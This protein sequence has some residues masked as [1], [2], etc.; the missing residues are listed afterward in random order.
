MPLADELRAESQ[1]RIGVRGGYPL[2]YQQA[3]QMATVIAEGMKD[4]SPSSIDDIGTI[5]NLVNDFLVGYDIHLKRIPNKNEPV[6][7]HQSTFFL[8]TTPLHPVSLS[9]AEMERAD[10]EEHHWDPS[11]QLEETESDRK[12]KE[13]MKDITGV[14]GGPFHTVIW[15]RSG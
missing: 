8:S 14:E 12:V 5:L 1:P 4:R 13:V 11:V 15:P 7:G 6:E 3:M 9:E 10:R 2:T